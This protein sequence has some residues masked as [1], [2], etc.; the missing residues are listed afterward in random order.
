[1]TINLPKDVESSIN[2]EVV[3]GRFAS[4]EDAIA[5]AWQQYLERRQGVAGTATPAASHETPAPPHKPIWEQIEEITASVPEDEFLKLPI[6]G[7]EQHDHYIY[8][9]PKRPAQ[10]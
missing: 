7:A 2:A 8:G 4:A 10:T 6:D 1:M 5:Q 3:S 9:L